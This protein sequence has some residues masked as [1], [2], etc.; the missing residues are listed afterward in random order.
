MSVEQDKIDG[1]DEWAN[2]VGGVA[3]L[4]AGDQVLA[5]STEPIVT[6]GSPEPGVVSAESLEPSV[7]AGSPEPRECVA[8]GSPKP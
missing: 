5:G 7:V 8:A 4:S 6:A 2:G 3:V 1:E